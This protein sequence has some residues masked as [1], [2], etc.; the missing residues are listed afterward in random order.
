MDLFSLFLQTHIEAERI[1]SDMTV[2]AADRYAAG[3]FRDALKSLRG[4][5]FRLRGYLPPP[6]PAPVDST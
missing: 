5:A 1:A 3:Q 2:P 4:T 6:K